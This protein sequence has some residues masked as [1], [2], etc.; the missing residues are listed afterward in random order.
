MAPARR[1]SPPASRWAAPA[2]G[3]LL[4]LSLALAAPAAADPPPAGEGRAR[5]SENYQTAQQ[6][7]DLGAG[8]FKKG[9]FREA[10]QA[11]EKAKALVADP[12]LIYY[13]GRS[14]EELGHPRQALLAYQEILSSAPE[15]NEGPKALEAIARL[16]QQQLGRLELRCQPEGAQVEL[17]GLAVGRCPLELADLPAGKRL[18]RLRA[19]G[20]RTQEL[21]LQLVP[22]QEVQAMAVLEAEGA[23]VHLSSIPTGADV[24]VDGRTLG[25]TPLNSVPLSPGVHRFRF[26][27]EGHLPR[28]R[29]IDLRPGPP[30]ALEATLEPEGAAGEGSAQAAAGRGEPRHGP[31]TTFWVAA[32]ASAVLAAG[33][34]AL[35][36]L[37]RADEAEANDLAQSRSGSRAAWQDVH[38]R[39][40]LLAT[41]ANLSFAG[42]GIGA[43]TALLFFW[44]EGSPPPPTPLQQTGPASWLWSPESGAG[45]AMGGCPL[46]PPTGGWR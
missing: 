23:L 37:A 10:L 14:H 40:E 21:T 42:A 13:V 35:G 20:Y 32:S 26:T 46:C 22:G 15:S 18:L 25:K 6:Y 19:P 38:G 7:I 11:F 29:E 36:L 30:S 31:S 27:L 2:F 34:L 28:E 41:G 1:K 4:L 44:L 43:L 39:A 16:R 5:S 45:Q 24:E 9:S 8:L 3:L 17:D 33:G 12:R